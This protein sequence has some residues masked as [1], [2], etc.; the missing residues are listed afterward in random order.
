MAPTNVYFNNYQSST[1]QDT[2]ESLL[3]ESI[4]IYGQDVWYIPRTVNDLDPVFLADD[5]SSYD[6]SYFLEVYIKNVDGFTGDGRFLSKF[7]I[8]IRD[9]ITFSLAFRTFYN[10]VTAQNEQPRPNE[11]D[12][13]FWPLNNKIYVIKYVQHEAIFYQFGALKLYDLTCESWEYSSE[14]LNTGIPQIDILQAE[15]SIGMSNYG[16]LTDVNVGIVPK[17]LQT[18]DMFDLI[19]EGYELSKQDTPE[20]NEYDVTRAQ[21]FLDFSEIN[22]FGELSIETGDKN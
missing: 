20:E 9:E 2:A 19:Q 3:I 4:K 13:I 7:N 15:L 18:E 11:G 17:R 22:P 12:I 6:A 8:E 10:E 16:L 14:R 21:E 1:E 5:V